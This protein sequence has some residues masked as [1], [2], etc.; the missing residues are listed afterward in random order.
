MVFRRSLWLQIFIFPLF[1]IFSH[2][3]A[4]AED[5]SLTWDPSISSN[6]AG[7]RVYTGTGSRSYDTFISIENQTSY[8]VTGLQAGTH[9][10]AVTA[11]DIDGYESDYSNEVLE[12]I[13]DQSDKAL[14]VI[15]E[16]SNSSITLNSAILSWF[17]NKESDTQVEYGTT[18][19]YSSGAAVDSTMVTFH[20]IS[21]GNLTAGTIYH[22][23]VKSQDAAGNLAV[24]ND[25]FFTTA[26]PLDNT[27][28][29]ILN[30]SSSNI[31]GNSAIISWSTNEASD[32]QVEYGTTT[33]YNSGAGVDSTMAAFHSISLGNLTAGTI[34]HYRVKSQ[35]AAGNL[36]VSSDYFFTTA[37]PPDNTP[38]TILNV[39]SSN[40]TSNSAIISW[41]TNE[42]S[43]TQVEYGTTTS[44]SSGAAVDSTMAAFHSISLGKLTAGTIYHYRVKSKDAAG[45]PA[46]S[47]DN[48]FTT[49]NNSNPVVNISSIVV[50]NITDRSAKISWTTDRP[51]DS[52]VDYWISNSAIQKSEFPIFV[53]QHTLVLNGLQK[54]TTYHF[55]IKSTD[56][57]GNHA[58]SFDSDFTTTDPVIPD[59]VMPRFSAGQNFL[60][61]D[62]MS[63]LGFTNL[64]AQS[65]A[66]K[67]TVTD[68]SGNLTSAPDITNPVT[69]QLN[70]M[71]QMPIVDLQLFGNGLSNSNSNG[72]IKLERNTANTHGFFLVFDSALSFMDGANFADTRLTDFVFTDIQTDGYNKISI[73]NN[74]SENAT[75]T[76]DLVGSD[77]TIRNSQSRMIQDRGALTADLYSDVFVGNL[78]NATDYVRVKSSNGV[79]SFDLLR[80]NMGDAA[81]LTGQDISAGS[82]VL[83]S[84]QYAV[85]GYIRTTLSVINLDSVVGTVTF[86]FINESGIQLGATKTLPI[87]PNGK[88]Y[89]EDQAFFLTT[90]S[91]TL[92]SGYVEITSSGVRLKGS[93]MF[94]D[95]NRRSF[96]TALELVSSL[97]TSLLFSHVT[98][99]DIYYTGLAF[100]NPNAADALVAIKIYDNNGSLVGSTNELLKARQRVSRTIT[101]YIPSMIGKNQSSGYVLVTSDQP[102]A[103][104]AL[105]GTNDLSIMSA[106][107]ALA[108]Q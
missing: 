38:P 16:V 6:I 69:V 64:D 105:F 43:D 14:P 66:L 101:Q 103:S 85:G 94:G 91:K 8:T 93:S 62:T 59:L 2:F 56:E 33:A 42:A 67:F 10:F 54:S 22:Y 9:Y 31:T 26:V 97:Q 18:T 63:G 13:D 87:A 104:F 88:I 36:A 100:L 23:R 5:V 11:C 35:D 12:I 79:Q 72:W 32:T 60:G 44:Y 86:R 39:S 28:P 107:P 89:I 78:P 4:L 84:P 25:Y 57:D 92:V 37:V 53:V 1:F 27:P 108:I 49:K 95:S 52:E 96:L 55:H 50:T 58:I 17:T 46:V 73:V 15:F 90:D 98:S 30:V 71:A 19:S 83:Y 77:G 68:D 102:I 7:Y 99:T 21:L 82:T 65:T 40:I 48:I 47:I 61:V 106:I 70:S 41:S 20:S 76:F 74:N 24:S 75:V 45:N 81:A 3:R 51:A 29:T 34:Y 80:Q